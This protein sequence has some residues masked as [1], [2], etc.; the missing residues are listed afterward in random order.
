MV[1]SRFHSNIYK[2]Y[3]YLF[4]SIFPN[5]WKVYSCENR[6]YVILLKHSSHSAYFFCLVLEITHNFILANNIH[7]NFCILW[8]A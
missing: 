5:R 6:K 2:T 7:I 8:L 4:V 1:H 3:L